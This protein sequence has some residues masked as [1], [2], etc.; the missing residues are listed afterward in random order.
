MPNKTVRMEVRYIKC[1]GSG[2][3]FILFDT[4]A[5]PLDG[6]ALDALS[7]AACDRTSGIGADG[8]VL[9]VC[10]DGQFGMRMF[11]PDGSEAEMCGNGIRCVAR[12]AEGYIRSES[13]VLTSGGGEFPTQRMED[14]YPGIPT[15]GIDIAVRLTSPDFGFMSEGEESFIGRTIEALHPELR[16]TAINVGNP[17]IVAEVEHIDYAL[18]EELGHR[19]T[20]LTHL[21]PRGINVSLVE[22][23]GEQS[24]F[25]ATFERGA[26]I[27]PSCGT[28]MTSSATAMALVGR[29][30]Y[31]RPIEVANR[32]GAVRCLCSH[33]GGLH[34]LLAGNAT[35][36]SWGRA[37]CDGTRFEFE[38]LGHFDEEVRL[39]EA[40]VESLI[41]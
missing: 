1:H 24:I 28:A 40:F 37:T 11:N 27:T 25:V 34:T 5:Q 23:R 38:E 35:F 14:I 31:D 13:F 30:G 4:V 9:L 21:F 33:E 12:A 2:N 7:R 8:I 10:H 22:R 41:K 3:E 20:E 26:G 16:F 39:Y 6:V 18:L 36:T 15:Y 29:C 17:H 19:V 32:G